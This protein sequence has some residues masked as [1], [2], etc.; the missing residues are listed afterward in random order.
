MQAIKSLIELPRKGKALIVTDIQKNLE[1]FNKYMD[2][3]ENFINRNNYLILT[4]DYMQ[5][6][7]GR[8]CSIEILKN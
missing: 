2:I 5:G 4:G 1:D 7:G 3:W 6:F 8:D